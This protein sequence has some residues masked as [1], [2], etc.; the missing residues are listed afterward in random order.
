VVLRIKLLKLD[1]AIDNLLQIIKSNCGRFECNTG[2]ETEIGF[3]IYDNVYIGICETIYV[4]NF[5]K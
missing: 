3:H 4:I 5:D 1:L 2:V